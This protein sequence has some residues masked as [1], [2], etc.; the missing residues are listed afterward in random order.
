MPAGS[1]A[2]HLC[3]EHRRLDNLVK[4]ADVTEGDERRSVP[5]VDRAWK[6]EAGIGEGGG[7]SPA[8][9]AAVPRLLW[10]AVWLSAID[11]TSCQGVVH[12]HAVL[13]R[14]PADHQ[15]PRNLGDPMLPPPHLRVAEE[16]SCPPA[17]PVPY[18]GSSA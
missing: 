9:P 6:A 10:S 3:P 15:G 8:R 13:G 1:G 12:L 5:L 17:L 7:G 18:R 16:A 2:G 4:L 11:G 14:R